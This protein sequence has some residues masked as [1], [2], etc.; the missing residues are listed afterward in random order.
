MPFED[1]QYVNLYFT[2]ITPLKD[3]EKRLVEQQQ[4]YETVLNQLPADVAVFDAE[5]RYRF[6][7][8]AAISTPELRQ[9]IIG[10]DDFEY[11]AY[12]NRSDK[13][14]RATGGCR[15]EQAIRQRTVLAWEER[16]RTSQGERLALRHMQ[17]V[18]D[19]DNRRAADGYRLR[20]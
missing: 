19:P 4:F 2:D 10:H 20:H 14:A 6:V 7:N 11:A 17:A 13:M 15:F 3:A 18:F 16:L 1:D 5:H 9:W 8:P 12:R